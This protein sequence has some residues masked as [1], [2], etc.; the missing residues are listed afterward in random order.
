[1]IMGM[2][3]IWAVPVIASILI[4]GVFVF[5]PISFA[6]EDGDDDDD[7]RKKSKTLEQHCAKKKGFDKLVCEAIFSIQIMLGMVK[8]DVAQL[9]E[10]LE[11]I[12]STPGPPGA[13]GMTGMTGPPGPPGDVSAL[14]LRVDELEVWHDMDTERIDDLEARVAALEAGGGGLNP[15]LCDPSGDGAIDAIENL[16]IYRNFVPDGLLQGSANAILSLEFFGSA[17]DHS[18]PLPFPIP[19][20]IFDPVFPGPSGFPILGSNFNGK[21]DTVAELDALNAILMENGI[22][23]CTIDFGTPPRKFN[24]V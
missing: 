10:D 21:I 19:P 20:P 16:P 1:M 11:N 3:V 12:Q 23:L 5:S 17:V 13:T 18:P 22:Q 2:K 7:D 24:H 8:D 15:T 14:T 6:D 9:Q 4:L